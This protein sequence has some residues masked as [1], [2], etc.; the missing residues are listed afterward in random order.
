LSL[1]ISRYTVLMD[2]QYLLEVPWLDHLWRILRYL[3]L[4]L[5]GSTLTMLSTNLGLRMEA[6]VMPTSSSRSFVLDILKIVNPSY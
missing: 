2:L 4:G 6:L 3:S 5:L 1:I